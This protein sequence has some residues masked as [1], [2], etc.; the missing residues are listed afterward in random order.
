MKDFWNTRYKENEY[1]YGILPNQFFKKE[2]DKI[3]PSSIL[4]PAE[5]EGRNA[6]YAAKKGWNVTAFDYSESA[7]TKAI[8]LAE[9]QKATILYKVTRCI[10]VF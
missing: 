2:L 10:R 7:R 1:A 4:L 5:G 6:V 8:R 9:S 3:K